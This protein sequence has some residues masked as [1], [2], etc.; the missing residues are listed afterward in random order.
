MRL[1]Q[2]SALACLC[3]LLPTATVTSADPVPP[4]WDAEYVKMEVPTTVKANQTFTAKITMKNTGTQT[5][6]FI[7]GVSYPSSLRSQA[8]DGNHTWGTDFIIQGQ[9]TTVEPGQVFTYQS[10]LRAPNQPGKYAFQWRVETPAG[11]I[12]QPTAK[13][14]I[15]V[16]PADP[17]QQAP[18]IPPPDASGKRPLTFADFLYLGSFKL[19]NQVGNG[20]AGFSESGITLR[21][22]P[23][24][25]KRLLVNYT[26]PQG[27]LF[28]VAI[29]D[30][31]KLGK[32]EEGDVSELQTATVKK[33]WGALA[34]NNMGANGGLSW[35]QG[36]QTL[37]WTSYNG[38]W[39]GGDLPVL[40]ATKLADDGTMTPVGSWTVPDQKWHWGGV[41]RLPK[42]FANKYTGGKTLALGF[43]GYFSICA[44][45][46]RGPAL[47]VIAE[48]DPTETAVDGLTN[49]LS[50]G[51]TSA[52]RRP[53][54][55]FNANCGYWNNQP[56]YRGPGGGTWTYCDW[57]RSGV[58]IDHGDKQGYIAFVKLGTGRLGYDYGSITNAVEAHYW[59]FYDTRQMGQ[60]ARGVRET[61][62][63]VPYL[64]HVDVG[65]GGIVTGAVFDDEIR[66]LFVI[67]MQSY[68][69]GVEWYPLV[70]VYHL[71]K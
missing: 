23:D 53:G 62:H 57:C 29:P 13:L 55:Y 4:E 61:G 54:N 48:P 7:S 47:S 15:T 71:E 43:G 18:G 44:P 41:T 46:S 42:S 64:T 35:D 26:F 45:C 66:K 12:G 5:W 20:G 3:A 14:L 36:K 17:H 1:L 50:Y 58:M 25:T 30:L 51:G 16:G 60:V 40:Q 49:M 65:M 56:R 32:Y 52:A 24:G 68:K 59:Y 27:C 37:Y 70:H 8:P 2:A 34:Q 9:G 19:P 6:Q 10:D 21:K 33:V 39:T 22:L 67:R 38:Y 28:E 11:L 31:G 69:S 63:L